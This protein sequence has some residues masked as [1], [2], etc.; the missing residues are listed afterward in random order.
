MKLLQTSTNFKS[1]PR[2]G[3]PRSVCK[4]VAESSGDPR[5]DF[6]TGD[7]EIRFRSTD[8]SSG[9]IFKLMLTPA[10]MAEILGAIPMGLILESEKDS[11]S[12]VM[13][14]LRAI[15]DLFKKKAEQGKAKK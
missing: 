6:E 2:K 9:D 10:E 1:G 7:A 4:C 14:G 11:R 8:E 13:R 5:I 15:T 12:D 3:M